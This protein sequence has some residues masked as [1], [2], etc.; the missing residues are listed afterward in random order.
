MYLLLG[1]YILYTNSYRDVYVDMCVLHESR[2]IH[3]VPNLKR[4]SLSV[5]TDV[6]LPVWPDFAAA[7]TTAPWL[8]SHSKAALAVYST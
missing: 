5:F 8:L 7:A 4:S 6:R 3:A 1:V 2:H